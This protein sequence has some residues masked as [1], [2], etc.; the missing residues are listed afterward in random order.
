MEKLPLTFIFNEWFVPSCLSSGRDI[1]GYQE[2]MLLHCL[3]SV[4]SPPSCVFD[5]LLICIRDIWDVGLS[6]AYQFYD[7]E[8]TLS[9]YC[10]QLS[11]WLIFFH[12]C[13]L[14]ISLTSVLY[15][16]LL[17]AELYITLKFNISFMGKS[18]L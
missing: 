2:Q 9:F 4:S 13:T 17:R 5:T 14:L 6:A 7:L 3:R 1:K 11:R 18:L 8:E 15:L 12:L 10:N 16:S